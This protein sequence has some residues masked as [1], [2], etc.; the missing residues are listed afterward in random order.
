[1]PSVP[2]PVGLAI[3][4][5]GVAETGLDHV[6]AAP[7]K[8]HRIGPPAST[9]VLFP[10]GD[11]TTPESWERFVPLMRHLRPEEQRRS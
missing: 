8:G 1:M 4:P 11:G 10:L 9:A 7:V 5:E 2:V 6:M 3:G